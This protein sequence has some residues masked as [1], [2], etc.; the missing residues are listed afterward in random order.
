MSWRD[1]LAGL[2]G[3]GETLASPPTPQEVR[4]RMR[5]RRAARVAVPVTVTAVVLAAGAVLIPPLLR[6]PLDAVPAGLTDA[7]GLPVADAAAEAF[8]AGQVVEPGQDLAT[9]VAGANQVVT[10][11]EG[12]AIGVGVMYAASGVEE[13]ALV[14]AGDVYTVAW[15]VSDGEVVGVLEPEHV[16]APDGN[17]RPDAEIWLDGSYVPIS[18][19]GGP[20]EVGEYEVVAAVALTGVLDATSVEPDAVT[21]VLS[22]PIP[23]RIGEADPLAG[24]GECGSAWPE[25]VAGITDGY[26]LGLRLD[27]A[28][29]PLIEDEQ[30]R[31]EVTARHDGVEELQGWTGHP[32]VVLVADGTVIGTTGGMNDVGLDASLAPGESLGYDGYASLTACDSGTPL[33]AGTY[34][35][36]AIMSF[37]F[38]SPAGDEGPDGTRTDVT[39]VGG[40]WEITLD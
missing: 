39:A 12:F 24:L 10:Y 26:D 33:A 8:D 6:Q 15:L 38:E 4:R 32:W 7:C 40:P 9:V 1:E 20:A 23:L 3:A 29:A 36:Y 18:C 34:E 13:Y 22:E 25:G 27:A 31:V 35:V 16:T 2:A 5:R 17:V 11:E 21:A 19:D 30:L 14:P 28:G 37:F